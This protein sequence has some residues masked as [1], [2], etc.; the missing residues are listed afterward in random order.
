MPS[1]RLLVCPTYY[2]FDPVL[3]RHFGS[4]PSSYW[5]DLGQLLPVDA[6]IFWT[7]NKVCSSK[8][9]PDDVQAINEI[10]GRNV[11][12]WDNY[13]VN[14]GAVRSNHLYTSPLSDRRGAN[15]T[16]LSGHLCNPMNQPLLSLP[17][18]LG[19]AR[20]HGSEVDEQQIAHWMGA[21]CW[22][23]LKHDSRLFQ[24]AG[25]PAIDVLKRKELAALYSTFPG[26]AA[27][28]VKDWLSGEY[29]FDPSC[30]TD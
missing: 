11:L 13:P 14:D 23:Q 8:I 25:L 22:R 19:L 4:R 20:L 30:L 7:G 28:E 9:D 2:S 24:D 10:L 12:L 15:P 27:R 3:E 1:T 29:A 26:A 21:E 5:A 6:D 16:M 18:L 17:A